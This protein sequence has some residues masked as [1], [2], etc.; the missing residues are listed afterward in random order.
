MISS[1][2]KQCFSVLGP[3]VARLVSS[4]TRLY[5][6]QAVYMLCTVARLLLLV[7]LLLVYILLAWQHA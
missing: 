4:L 6:K 1:L 5:M 2:M 7:H 3:A